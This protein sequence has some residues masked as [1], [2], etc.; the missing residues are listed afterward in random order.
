MLR[1]KTQYDELQA[2]LRLR[3]DMANMIVH[4]M[5]SPLTT[6]MLKTEL[7]HQRSTEP[8]ALRDIEIILA[9]ARRLTSFAGDMLVLAKI[10]A[11]KLILNRSMVDLNELV[12]AAGDY[13]TVVA[14]SAGV[15]LVLDM[16]EESCRVSLDEGLFLR[17]LDNLL[18]NA[19]KFAPAGTSVILRVRYL[20]ERTETPSEGPVFR[21]QVLDEGP[22]IPE[23]HRERIFQKYE[24]LDIKLPQGD[25]TGTGLGLAFCKMVIDAHGGRITVDSNIPTGAIFTI[26]I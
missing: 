20:G 24:A 26:E 11:G 14:R 18:S 15:D 6:I 19:L 3:E 13:H 25:Q 4:D 5:R 8:E 7:L 10:Q 2:A 16:P 1:I 9:E 22:G 12:Y 23:V 21:L 17:V